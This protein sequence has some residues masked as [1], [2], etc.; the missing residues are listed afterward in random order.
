[1][2]LGKVVA[3]VLLFVAIAPFVLFYYKRR[4]FIAVFATMWALACL[5]LGAAYWG[6]QHYD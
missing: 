2:G 4:W 3:L 5:F 6:V 1:M